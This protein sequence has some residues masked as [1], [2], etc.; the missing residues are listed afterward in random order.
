M[1]VSSSNPQL[2]EIL[3]ADDHPL[4]RGALQ[5][6]IAGRYPGATLHTAAS[7]AELQ[8]QVEAH[9]GIG[10]LLMD[11][12]MPEMDGADAIR[13]IRKIEKSSGLS[14]ARILTLTA[15]EQASS[16]KQ[17]ERAGSDGFV[18]KPIEPRALVSE[19]RSC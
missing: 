3:I 15:D 1:A 9:L 14:P 4:F 12:H 19:L 6:V 5:Q 11:L 10:L 18:T 16:R 2:R 17:S 7:V 8:Q 13:A